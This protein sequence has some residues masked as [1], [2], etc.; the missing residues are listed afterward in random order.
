M[1]KI[2]VYK[3]SDEGYLYVNGIPYIPIIDHKKDRTEF[4][5]IDKKEIDM[6]VNKIIPLLMGHI[7]KERILRG[8]LKNTDVRNLAVIFKKLF[9]E[10]RKRKASIKQKDGCLYL[11]IGGA[12]LDIQE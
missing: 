1:K 4:A 3:R 7:D 11:N 10:K 9:D 6:M 8:A 2:K 5:P 12:R